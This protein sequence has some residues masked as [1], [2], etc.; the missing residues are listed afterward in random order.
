ML[1]P[2]FLYMM[3]KTRPKTNSKFAPQ[4][5]PKLTPPK[6][7]IRNLNLTQLLSFKATLVSFR[8]DSYLFVQ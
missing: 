7:E 8:E 6:K 2:F 3:L 1:K 5:R 4:N